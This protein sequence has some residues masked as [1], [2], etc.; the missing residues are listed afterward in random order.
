[1]ESNDLY[2]STNST[3]TYESLL[4]SFS[5]HKQRQYMYIV[6]WAPYLPP[7]PENKF[8]IQQ[9]PN[10]VIPCSISSNNGDAGSHNK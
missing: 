6:F 8:E 1:M 2:N 9:F 5:N 7:E 3:P 10:V 4:V